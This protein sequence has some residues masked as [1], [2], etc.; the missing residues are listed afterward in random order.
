MSNCNEFYLDNMMEVVAIPINDY[1][2]WNASAL[3]PTISK[4]DFEPTLDN[5]IVIG[6]DPVNDKRYLIPIRPGSGKANDD[7]GDS[8]YGRKHTVV[9][10]CEVDSRYDGILSLLRTLE[11]TP[12]HLILTFR[13]NNRAFVAATQDTYHCKVS[14]DGSKTQVQFRIEC[15]SGI[16][17]IV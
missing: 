8:V 12:C 5:A 9:V 17:L 6:M 3:Q 2:H 10:S 11:L 1:N 7:E 14:R 16:Q 15:I 13:N 4:D